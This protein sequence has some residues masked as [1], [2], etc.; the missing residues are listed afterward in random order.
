MTRTTRRT[1]ITGLSCFA[2]GAALPRALLAAEAA[3]PWSGRGAQSAI[4][5]L[6]GGP[7]QEGK[8]LA[9]LEIRLASGFKTYWRTPGASGVPPVFDW[10][11]SANLG[12][13]T[14]LW[15]RPIRF[16]EGADSAVGYG[17]D[18][19][20]PL[21]VT[22]TDPGKPV[23]LALK[24]DYAL[25]EKMCIPARG[26]AALELP[27]AATEHMARL[28]AA[29]AEVPRHVAF[30]PAAEGLALHAAAPIHLDGKPALRLDIAAPAD[31]R[32]EDVFV[33]GPDMWLFSP[34]RLIAQAE[35]GRWAAVALIENRP[36]HAQGP[37]PLL[38][39]LIGGGQA[40]EVAFE[41]D[42]AAP[43]P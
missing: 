14:V 4:R 38:A 23:V 7:T 12:G 24:L 33:E 41:L 10:S 21:V 25:C 8:L 27:A 2:A 32:L 5:L 36:K 35:A 17:G 34:P 6:G 13:V 11:G 22:P 28:E 31:A 1:L 43:K 26:E 39:T 20:L 15:P 40:A 19:V 18:V 37:Q 16:G 42:F 3:S 29:L 30:G 9:G